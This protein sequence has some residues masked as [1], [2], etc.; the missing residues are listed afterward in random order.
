MGSSGATGG[1]EIQRAW[2]MVSTE[3]PKIPRAEHSLDH[4]DQLPHLHCINTE[5]EA[6]RTGVTSPRSPRYFMKET[7]L[8]SRHFDSQFRTIQVTEIKIYINRE[9]KAFMLRETS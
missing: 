2:T 7:G 1:T 8:E 5:M 4:F 9:I 3:T 6:Q